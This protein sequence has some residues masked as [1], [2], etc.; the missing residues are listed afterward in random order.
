MVAAA[1]S[2]S[3]GDDT[4][5]S[6]VKQLRT[7]SALD[8]SLQ[9]AWCTRMRSLRRELEYCGIANFRRCEAS[10][11]ALSSS[12]V[13]K[14]HEHR[15]GAVREL[16]SARLCRKE[17][18]SACGHGRRPPKWALAAEDFRRWCATG[19]VCQRLS[20]MP[21]AQRMMA[22]HPKGLNSPLHECADRHCRRVRVRA[23]LCWQS[24]QNQSFDSAASAKLQR[25]ANASERSCGPSRG[26]QDAQNVRK[27][28]VLWC[29]KCVG[30]GEGK[31]AGQKAALLVRSLLYTSSI[32]AACKAHE[33]LEEH[34]GTFRSKFAECQGKW[35]G[36]VML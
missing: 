32:A 31:E 3:P 36:M 35:D 12:C 4:K 1:A 19:N 22:N 24:G 23:S 18:C 25:P 30:G 5:N 28:A 21:D 20:A 14:T 2:T 9:T 6:D 33:L 15:P 26:S 8:I 13:S 11:F 29:W 7:L 27:E 34:H 10:S 17:I 16:Y